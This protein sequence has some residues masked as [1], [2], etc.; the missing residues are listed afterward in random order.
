MKDSKMLPEANK[1]FRLISKF[2]PI[3]SQIEYKDTMLGSFDFYGQRFKTSR[4]FRDKFVNHNPDFGE[5]LKKQQEILAMQRQ[6]AK[7]SKW[8]VKNNREKDIQ[9][10]IDYGL[11]QKACKERAHNIHLSHI[12]EETL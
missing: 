6:E 3:G 2:P 11:W 10:R 7:F 5:L 4:L 9:A 8:C 12:K 1:P